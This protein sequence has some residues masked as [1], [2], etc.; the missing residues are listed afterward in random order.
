[1][2]WISVQL[3]HSRVL[4]QPAAIG[5]AP[6]SVVIDWDQDV[7]VLMGDDLESSTDVESD[8]E[9]QERLMLKLN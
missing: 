3:S 5:D 2:V 1:M 7:G 9:I 8:S 4:R 6:E